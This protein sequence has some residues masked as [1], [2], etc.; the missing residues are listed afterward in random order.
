M[1]QQ[2]KPR[3]EVRAEIRQARSLHPTKNV[4]LSPS[5]DVKSDH[6]VVVKDKLSG[7][8]QRI[9]NILHFIKHP[10]CT[11]LRASAASQFA[12]VSSSQFGLKAFG[13]Q[14]KRLSCTFLTVCDLNSI[15]KLTCMYEDYAILMWF[16][17]PGLDTIHPFA[18]HATSTLNS[19]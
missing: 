17:I 10:R 9:P 6:L 2:F 12:L 13:S 5:C 4:L 19:F 14:W 8:K 7:E 3:Q 15:V 18:R 16:C 11:W 1:K